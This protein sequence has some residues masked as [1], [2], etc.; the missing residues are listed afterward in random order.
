MKQTEF[1]QVNRGYWQGIEDALNRLRYSESNLP[2]QYQLL[3]HHLAIARSRQYSDS[4]IQYLES[5][6]L[7][8]HQLLYANKSNITERAWLFFRITVPQSFRN[9][10]QYS[11]IASL[12]FFLP[13][14]ILPLIIFYQNSISDY[15][16]SA[17]TMESIKSMYN[18]DNK[19][20]GRERVD[21]SDWMMF[22][23]YVYNNTGI[24]FR[25]FATGF[26]IGLGSAF[27]LL[28]NGIY[29]G[30][31]M[32][33]LVSI[34]YS[35]SFFSFVA[36]HSA[37]ELTAIMLSGAAGLILGNAILKPGF[38][39]RKHAIKK[40]AK[41]ALPLI[42]AAM[43]LF[44]LAAIIEAFWS[45]RTDFPVFVKYLVGILL[46]GALFYY[47]VFSGRHYRGS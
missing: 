5:L 16:L 23:Y 41:N 32:G 15:I 44:F 2:E 11:V 4:L 1:V 24:G 37:F 13:L 45:S 19:S 29:I 38:H 3:S 17:D 39:S 26:F 6:I 42:T 8:Q 43:I 20:L 10:Y 35:E 36:G 22:G 18:P 25:T 21:D 47:F 12:L 40:A 27:F 9:Q 46:W 28:Y 33:Y 7:K 30:A 14:I 31:V 34:G